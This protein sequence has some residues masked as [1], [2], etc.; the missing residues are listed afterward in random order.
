MTPSDTQLPHAQLLD[1]TGKVALVTGAGRGIGRAIAHVLA[2]AG[3]KVALASRTTEQLEAV[4][5]ELADAG[6][7]ADRTLVLPTDVAEETQVAATIQRI[8]ETW[9]RLDILVNNAGLIDFGPLEK[10]EPEGWHRVIEANLTGPYLCSRA[11]APHL[12]ASG[13]GRII[14]I[15]SVSAQTGGVS[16]GV[17]YTASKGGLAAMTKT[18]ARDLASSGVTVN[19]ISPGQIDADPNLL[20]QEQRQHVTGLIPLGRLGEPEEIAY[21]ALF[22]A[23]PMAAYITGT[24]IDVNGGIL[25]R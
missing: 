9:G 18:L 19:S 12:S 8:M 23:S 15:T 2:R 16:G 1:L 3:A 7:D 4:A 20:T 17:H 10:I 13:E 6:V 21:A 24:T 14:N 22:L 5:G 25:K 11:A